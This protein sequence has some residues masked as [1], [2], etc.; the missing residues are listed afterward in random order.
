[1]RLTSNYIGCMSQANVDCI[2]KHN[3]EIAPARVKVCP[4]NIEVID[5]SIDEK[6]RIFIRAK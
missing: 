4:N 2:L 6:T 5:K 3:L 1:M